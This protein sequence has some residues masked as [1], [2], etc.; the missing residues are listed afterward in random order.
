MT[1]IG[2]TGTTGSC[3]PVITLSFILFACSVL[4]LV[5]AAA[6][7]FGSRFGLW[8]FR[9]GFGILRFCCIGGGVVGVASLIL[10][11]PSVGRKLPVAIAVSLAAA[12]LGL[13]LAGKG[14][15]W[16]FKAERLPR[17]HDISTDVVTPPNF[18]V[19]LPLRKGAANPT[20]YGG[21][22]VAAQQKKAYPEIR[23][24]VINLSPA[25]AFAAC[26]QAARSLGWK[27]VSERPSEGIIE[28]TDTTFWFGFTDD[29]V[30]RV[31]RAGE[32]RSLVDV[33]SLSRVGIGDMGTNAARIQ[34]FLKLL[35]KG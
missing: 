20:E 1:D 28:A 3:S 31:S 4:A 29:I 18:S 8:H 6:A 27:I 23:T 35:P 11:I 22:A 17:I 30:V 14:L 25:S 19:L 9:T 13:G 34:A 15:A 32:G 26:L 12:I 10:L 24:A 21:A 7:G 33:R 16:K 5:A 2:S